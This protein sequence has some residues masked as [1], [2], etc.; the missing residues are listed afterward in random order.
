MKQT[1]E[2]DTIPEDEHTASLCP[3]N[4]QII[5]STGPSS[6]YVKN[7]HQTAG[8][9]SKQ[10]AHLRRE[11]LGHGGE[12]QEL[13][14]QGLVIAAGGLRE[15]VAKGA[16]GKARQRA[17]ALPQAQPHFST[18]RSGLLLIYCCSCQQ[19]GTVKQDDRSSL[20]TMCQQHQG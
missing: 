4:L 18:C 14:R 20:T 12:A 17:K 15:E 3:Y 1:K 2:H 16:A 7:R 13:V 19:T 9:H 10:P 5:C 11:A 8:I 6:K